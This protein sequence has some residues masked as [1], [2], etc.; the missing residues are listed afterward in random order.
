MGAPILLCGEEGGQGNFLP[1][2]NYRNIDVRIRC[3]LR[4][5]I[6]VSSLL[7]R[8]KWQQLTGLCF[9]DCC[10]GL[11]YLLPLLIRAIFITTVSIQPAVGS[12]D[13]QTVTRDVDKLYVGGL[14]GRQFARLPNFVRSKDG[15]HGCLASIDL[16]GRVWTPELEYSDRGGYLSDIADDVR[17]FIKSGCPGTDRWTY[18]HNNI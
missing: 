2:I 9:L 5:I 15:F 17:Q 18:I 13:V 11:Y 3:G 12:S 4:Q 14:P 10:L 16:D 8:Q 7:W 1:I 6:L